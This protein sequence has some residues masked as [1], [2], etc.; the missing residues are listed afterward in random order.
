VTSLRILFLGTAEIAVP[1]L[2]ALVALPKVHTIAVVTQP[3]ARRGRGRT[4]Q[5]SPVHQAALALDLEVFTP[6]R[7]RGIKGDEILAQ[8]RPQAALVMAYGQLISGEHLDRCARGWFNLHAS[9][10]PRWRGAAPIERCLE[11]GD[12]VTGMGLMAMQVE[13]DTGPVYA[14]IKVPTGTHNA[15]S[16]ATE[17]GIAAAQLVRR[18]LV[19]TLLGERPAKPQAS[20]GM[21]YAKRIRNDEGQI[22]FLGNA[23]DWAAKARAFDPRLGL[24]CCLHTQTGLQPLK[25]WAC[26][27]I[28]ATPSAKPGLILSVSKD[29]LVVA[30]EHGAL[31]VETLQSDGKKRLEWSQFCAGVRIVVGDHLRAPKNS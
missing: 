1:A 24:R 26:T 14:E 22:N 13:L 7:F 10:L 9:L 29:A 18:D 30:C 23:A 12:K 21:T 15:A 16:L 17:L 2:G 11:A 6:E 25:I 20:V 5:R 31:R 19:A 27:A 28:A 8:L 4:L 3:P